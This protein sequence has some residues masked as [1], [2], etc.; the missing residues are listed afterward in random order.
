MEAA[1]ATSVGG[2]ERLVEQSIRDRIDAPAFGRTSDGAGA[3]A[4]WQ[5]Q[6]EQQQG[7]RAIPEHRHI[8]KEGVL[9]KRTRKAPQRWLQRWARL[10]LSRDATEACLEF[11]AP[12]LRPED[13]TGRYGAREAAAAG[14][15]TKGQRPGSARPASA[16]APSVSRIDVRRIETA[17]AAGGCVVA[18]SLVKSTA[19]AGHTIIDR[20][21]TGVGGG[22]GGNVTSM[23]AADLIHLKTAV[24]EEAKAWAREITEV[25]MYIDELDKERAQSE[26][27][28]PGE[29]AD[30]HGGSTA[31]DEDASRE[32]ATSRVG[33][34]DEVDDDPSNVNDSLRFLLPRMPELIGSPVREN[35]QQHHYAT[36]MIQ[37]GRLYKELNADTHAKL[38]ETFRAFTRFGS[39]SGTYREEGESAMDGARFA[40][41]CRDARIVNG[42]NVNSISVDIVFAKVKA[43]GMRKIK[44]EQF[45]DALALL[46]IERM[47]SPMQIVDMILDISEAGP[48]K[49]KITTAEPVRLHD[50]LNTYTGVYSRG[51]PDV[52]M[53][54]HSPL[55]FS[56]RLR[57]DRPASASSASLPLGR[58]LRFDDFGSLED[59]GQDAGAG[60]ASSS[61]LLGYDAAA[62]DPLALGAQLRRDLDGADL[63]ALREVFWAFSLFGADRTR[64]RESSSSSSNIDDGSS[65]HHEIAAQQRQDDSLTMDGAHFAKLVR[66]CG[67]IEGDLDATQTDIIFSRVCK[68]AT[69]SIA[70]E[71]NADSGRDVPVKRVRRIS[72][73]LFLGALSL[74]ADTKNVDPLIL[75]AELLALGRSGPIASGATPVSYVPLHDNK[76]CYT[77]V[78]ANGGPEVLD[79]R[80]TLQ[81]MVSREPKRIHV[82]DDEGFI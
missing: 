25:K 45:V 76:L 9:L 43:K 4:V 74:A 52:N 54:A 63:R 67:L 32:D 5:A 27:S 26:A 64:Q 39:G 18:I 29:A 44:Y 2:E 53:D 68:A 62:F 69:R 51:G 22:E 40:K 36:I 46:A 13:A 50:D 73:N 11:F 82:P 71:S 77:G 49:N 37:S 6:Q 66:D 47:V 30:G 28:A 78:Y 33:L 12:P 72:F 38:H 56:R 42:K 58:R 35:T 80:L 70:K 10:S 65:H 23:K 1:E 81:Q 59:C 17:T 16:S 60:A 34:R 15:R 31:G 61:F 48:V 8:M 7:Q 21:A 75:S 3:G 24:V 20:R 14:G 19:A 79:Q 55:L 57:S 41:L